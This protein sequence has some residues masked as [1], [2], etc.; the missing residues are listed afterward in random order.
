MRRLDP[1]AYPPDAA[2]PD[3]PG[4]RRGDR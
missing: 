3:Q 4:N 2:V 1:E